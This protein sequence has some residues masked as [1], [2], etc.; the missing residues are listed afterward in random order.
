MLPWQF[1]SNSL[2]EASN[3]LVG[4]ANFISKVYFSRL[5]L[6]GGSVSMS[7]VDF[8]ISL[9]LLAMRFHFNLLPFYVTEVLLLNFSFHSFNV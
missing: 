4:N 3:S 5:I 7:L 1:F 2:A 9:G 8:F 6:P